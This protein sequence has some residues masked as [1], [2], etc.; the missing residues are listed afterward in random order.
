MKHHHLIISLIVLFLCSLAPV[1]GQVPSPEERQLQSFIDSYTKQ[2]APLDEKAQIAEWNAYVTGKKEYY[3]QKA[4]YEL[5]KAL[6]HSDKKDYRKLV[7]WKSSGKIKDPLLVRQLDTLINEFG[8][9]QI[10]RDLLERISKKE[11]EVEMTFNTCR[12]S[13]DGKE[14]SDN[15]IYAVLSAEKDRSARKKAWEAQKA[16]GRKVAPL[17]RELVKLRNEGARR[18]GFENYYVMTIKFDDQDVEELAS[19]FQ[20]L[21]TLTEDAFG[22]NKRE[23][24]EIVAR[25]LGV[26]PQE[27]MPW[28]YA[29]PFFQD[30]PGIFT[31]ETGRYFQ[32]KNFPD[33]VSKFY[34][35]AGLPVSDVLKRSD[36]YEKPGKSQHAFCYDIN[37]KG[38]IR[39]LLNMREDEDSCSTLLHEL[40][41]GVYDKYIDR[42]LPWLLREPANTFTTEAV[43]MMFE[44]LTKNASWLHKM[45]GVPQ[46]Q[47]D[48]LR[49]TLKK[50]LALQQLVFCRWTEVMFN[51]ERALYQNPDQDLNTL[52]W[53]M[54]EKYQRLKRPEGRNEPDWASKIHFTSAPVY[55][56]NYMLGEL[57]AS[58]LMHAVGMKVLD[59]KENWK[60]ID[61]VD[62]PALGMWLRK[63]FLQQGAS[64]KW[65]ELIKRATGE[66]LTPEF[67]AEQ[68]IGQKQR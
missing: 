57:T 53:D 5:H 35:G 7:D 16:V 64:Y 50:D 40:G 1:N 61:F 3:Q 22:E 18:L 49:S 8:P 31:S 59:N 26:E 66:E 43:A 11:A 41:H 42:G 21:Y 14:V 44:R 39:V 54:V 27:L 65:N 52:W 33:I 46:D 38:D 68:F 6:I 20:K 30:A 4:E 45:I 17:L 60:E 34:D 36:L 24:D 48:S 47:A 23:M 9:N 32:G 62:T 12:A 51:F 13:I 28:D 19:I 25:R 55:Y 10:D 37:R 67:F 63:N 58:Q 15:D 2:M 29:N 56:H